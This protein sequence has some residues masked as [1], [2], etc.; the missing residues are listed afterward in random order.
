M[1]YYRAPSQKQLAKKR[2][3]NKQD[4]DT[5]EAW[6]DYKHGK[7][8]KWNDILAQKDAQERIEHCKA[9]TYIHAEGTY[10]LNPMFVNNM[11][12]MRDLLDVLHKGYPV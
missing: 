10:Q 1:V 6:L 8:E 4:L 7:P 12:Q 11:R 5:V 2:D 9:L 3:W